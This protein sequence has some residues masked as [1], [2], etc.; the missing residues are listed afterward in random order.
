MSN[1]NRNGILYVAYTKAVV[2]M[3]VLVD[4]AFECMSSVGLHTIQE[5]AR[6]LY[7]ECSHGKHYLDG[8]RNKDGYLVGIT[9]AG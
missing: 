9:K 6:G 4:D 1:T 2:G 8:Q 3:Q 7:L 5:D